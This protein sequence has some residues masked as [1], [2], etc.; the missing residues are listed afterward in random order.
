MTYFLSASCACGWEEDHAFTQ[1]SVLF[2][3]ASVIRSCQRADLYAAS[4]QEHS[5]LV[6]PLSEQH[7]PHATRT[8]LPPSL[9]S[10]KVDLFRQ[11]LGCS[12]SADF[13][14]NFRSHPLPHP[15]LLV[16]TDYKTSFRLKV[17]PHN[18]A[19]TTEN[20]PLSIQVVHSSTTVS[21]TAGEALQTQTGHW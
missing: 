18:Q 16:A 15:N 13:R 11:L 4:G 6:F 8:A 1:K 2:L 5:Y 20:K 10:Q 7:A 3:E 12:G 14:N 21:T 9:V 19:T 17:K